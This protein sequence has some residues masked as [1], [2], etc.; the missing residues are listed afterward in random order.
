MEEGLLI[1]ACVALAGVAWYLW[2]L[3]A[4]TAREKSNA[5]TSK[6]ALREA[7]ERRDC[8]AAEER[9]DVRDRS[10]NVMD[11]IPLLSD[12]PPDS[13]AG[14]NLVP[15]KEPQLSSLR[16][17]RITRTAGDSRLTYLETKI[18]GYF[19]LG[20]QVW[21]DAPEVSRG[22]ICPPGGMRNGKSIA[23][24]EDASAD[25]EGYYPC[26]VLQ[27]RTD[28]RNRFPSD[29]DQVFDEEEEDDMSETYPTYEGSEKEIVP[30]EPINVP[31]LSQNGLTL[32]NNPRRAG[33][34]SVRGKMPS[35][36]ILR[37]IT[38][39]VADFGVRLVVC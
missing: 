32:V 17:E 8:E 35:H 10:G 18:D 3:K 9:L 20:D 28:W 12:R 30:G 33:E 13:Q 6:E 26:V 22:G 34:I 5:E 7:S 16:H 14:H 4:K 15:P 39:F 29:V 23:I 19:L 2:R 11:D 27:I 1:V 21:D 25:P 38:N 24:S 37:Q 36:E 31:L